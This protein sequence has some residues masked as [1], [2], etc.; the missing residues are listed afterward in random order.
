[1]A[2]RKIIKIDEDKCNGCAL[3]IPNCPEGALKVIDGKVRLISDLFC[4]GLGAC[5]GYCP[6][7]AITIEEREAEPY[8]ERK[9]ME[10][11]VKQGKNT[12]KAHL[13]HLKEHNETRYLNEAIKF[14]KEKNIKIQLEDDRMEH[15][16]FGSCPGAAIRDFRGKED[17]KADSSGSIGQKSELR[18]WPVQLNLLPPGAP[19]FQDSDLLIAADCVP[20]ANANFHSELLK[21]K[22]LV[23][24]CPKLDD[25]EAYKE[26]IKSIIEMNELNTITTAIMEVPCCHGLYAVTEEALNE[27]GKR[28]TLK[29]VVV[30]VD[31][32]IIR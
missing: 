31:G 19:F 30:G 32:K 9:V 25:V 27:S 13:E 26:K 1:M 18:Q 8:D 5:I 17:K 10:N 4:D 6:E 14:L 16:H 21:G 28:I 12:I 7:G 15:S 2:K 23:I 29:K 11:I 24:G 20:F 22:S 3:C